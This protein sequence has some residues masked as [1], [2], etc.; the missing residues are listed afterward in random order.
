MYSNEETANEEEK[1]K[2]CKDYFFIGCFCLPMIW[3]VNT[4]WFYRMAFSSR[5][6]NGKTAM[7]KILIFFNKVNA[8]L[9]QHGKKVNQS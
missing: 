4:V 1:V 8:K 3:L 5:K 9:L 2:L 6:F 7:R